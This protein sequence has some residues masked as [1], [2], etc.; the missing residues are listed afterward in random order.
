MGSK[1]GKYEYKMRITLNSSEA[2]RDLGVIVDKELKFSKHVETQVNK[3]NRILGLVRRSFEH[4]DIDSMRMLFVG[5]IRPHLEFAVSTWN[6]R[7]E[8]DKYLIEGV[9]RRATK[10]IPGLR[11]LE[12]EQRLEKM[13]IPSMCY[14]RI[15]GDM[16]ETYKFT[17]GLYNCKSPLERSTQSQ[18][19]GHQYKLAKKFCV[20]SMRQNFFVN[21]VTDTW[22]ALSDK[23]VEAPTVNSF[24]NRFDAFFKD[25]R[26]ASNIHLPLTTTVTNVKC[27]ATLNSIAAATLQSISLG[28]GDSQKT[29]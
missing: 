24:K 17:H 18:T 23:I 10:C 12:Y 9:L 11:H 16:I 14:R 19:R 2:E 4:L 22:N 25:V 7:F 29:V 1:N 20:S 6:P 5:L 26:Y 27:H 3:V 13:Q 15:R 28:L 8:K 21:R